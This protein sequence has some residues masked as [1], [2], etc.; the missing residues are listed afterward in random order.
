MTE[1][2]IQELAEKLA[3][4]LDESPIRPE[5][6]LKE[7]GIGLKR[8]EYLR[9]HDENFIYHKKGRF[10]WYHRRDIK[11]WISSGRVTKRAS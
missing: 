10:I 6:V 1:I 2:D 11:A 3:T 8:Q 4:Y 7:F 5:V 9:A